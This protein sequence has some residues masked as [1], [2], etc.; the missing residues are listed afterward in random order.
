MP[1]QKHKPDEAELSP[2]VPLNGNTFRQTLRAFQEHHRACFN[3]RQLG[4][5]HEIAVEEQRRQLLSKKYQENLRQVNGGRSESGRP[6]LNSTS[7]CAET[8][9]WQAYWTLIAFMQHRMAVAVFDNFWGSPP[10]WVTER[11]MVQPQRSLVAMYF[12]VTLCN[13]D[14]T[15]VRILFITCK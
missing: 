8:M 5:V 3:R 10:C 14:L 15:V 11:N 6:Q 4:R 2:K 12:Y 13:L 7:D 9:V 1:V